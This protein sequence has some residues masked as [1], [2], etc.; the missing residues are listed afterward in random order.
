MRNDDVEVSGVVG[1]TSTKM[2]YCWVNLLFIA[3]L[4]A[5]STACYSLRK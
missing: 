3:T 5:S 2:C 4:L 1:S